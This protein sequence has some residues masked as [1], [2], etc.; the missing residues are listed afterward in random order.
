MS[1]KK[2]TNKKKAEEEVYNRQ[3]DMKK[4]METKFPTSVAEIETTLKGMKEIDADL[5]KQRSELKY[6]IPEPEKKTAAPK[7]GSYGYAGMYPSSYIVGTS[8]TSTK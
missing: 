3:C 5:Y 6:K 7:S 8:T 2:L 4:A 1:K